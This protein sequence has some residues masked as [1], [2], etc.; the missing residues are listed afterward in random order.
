M[1]KTNYELAERISNGDDVASLIMG[2]RRAAQAVGR[3]YTYVFAGKVGANWPGLI[4]SFVDP[5]DPDDH[6][7]NIFPRLYDWEATWGEHIQTPIYRRKQTGCNNTLD[8]IP[9]PNFTGYTI[10]YSRAKNTIGFSV[11]VKNFPIP[12]GMPVLLYFNQGPKVVGFG[13][14]SDCNIQIEPP[15]QSG[16]PSRWNIQFC[17]WADP[18][19]IICSGVQLPP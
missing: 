14:P 13:L 10:D 3:E 4:P 2:K 6:P 12:A 17:H 5:S 16:T 19:S 11:H 8:G 7:D 15:D 1:I 18:R 9:Y